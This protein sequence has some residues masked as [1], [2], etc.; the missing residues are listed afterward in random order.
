M[1]DPQRIDEFCDTLKAEWHKV[2]DW[3]FTQ[4]MFNIFGQQ[5]PFY[6]EDNNALELIK[7]K[8]KEFFN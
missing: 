2:P 8:M 6:L 5:M 4:L 3:R 1:R 7:Q